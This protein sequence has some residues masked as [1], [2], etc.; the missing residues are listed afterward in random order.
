MTIRLFNRQSLP[1]FLTAVFALALVVV[2]LAKRGGGTASNGNEINGV[3]QDSSGRRVTA[4]LDPMYSQGPPHIYKSNAPGH[5]PDCGMR[6]VPLYADDE[7]ASAST[8]SNVRGY[9]NVSLSPVRQQL[10][11]VKL[12]TA[13]LGPLAGGI[14]TIGVVAADERRQS[15]VHTK[16]D[17]VIENLYVNFTGQPVRRGDPLLSVYS[18]D[19][20]A[21][22]QE[23]ILAERMHSDFGRTLADAARHRLLLWDMSAGDI[24][25]VARNGLPIRAVTLR[26]PV[27]GIVLTKSALLGMRVTTAD[28]LYVVADLS[29]VWILADVYELDLSFVR[30]GQRA[31]VTLASSDQRLTGRVTFVSPVVDEVTRTAKVRIEL[32]NPGGLFKPEMYANVTLEKPLANVITV[33]D[34]AVMQTG[35]RSIVFVQTAP[36]QFTPREVQAGVKAEGLYEIRSGVQAGETVVAD[37]NFLVDSESRL[38]SAI[39]GMGGMAGMSGTGSSAA[40]AKTKGAANPGQPMSNMPGMSDRKPTGKQ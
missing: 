2:L 11:G 31:Q 19:L 3:V 13:E 17:G 7:P 22:Q 27:S 18:P 37:A 28:T 25:R 32:P 34:S 26:S 33:P 14:R 10:I 9:S 35:T 1:W 36:G 20:L 40:P 12:A 15:Q 30:A 6:L 21:T 23:L 29:S 38:K 4:W 24:D 16:F 39:S 5:A 8:P